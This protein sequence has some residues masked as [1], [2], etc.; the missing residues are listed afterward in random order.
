MREVIIRE[1]AWK[2]N[3]HVAKKT[4]KC[5]IIIL[6]TKVIILFC[7]LCLYRFSSWP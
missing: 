3:Q 6:E 4:F 7:V 5:D 1:M 2:G